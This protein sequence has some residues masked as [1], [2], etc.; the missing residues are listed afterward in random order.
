VKSQN[1]K[2]NDVERRDSSL[3]TTEGQNSVNLFRVNLVLSARH[4]TSNTATT[5]H[6]KAFPNNQLILIKPNRMF[7][8]VETSA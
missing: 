6:R 8:L 4:S 3:L 5:L 2:F 1:S 7:G